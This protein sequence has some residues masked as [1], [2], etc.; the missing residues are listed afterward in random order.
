MR[1]L[2]SP[3]SGRARLAAHG[4]ESAAVCTKTSAN[5]KSAADSR[6]SRR[7]RRRRPTRA[8]ATEASG[9]GQTRPKQADAGRCNRR[10]KAQ[11]TQAGAAEMGKHH[12]YASKHNRCVL[13]SRLNRSRCKTHQP[14]THPHVSQPK[15]IC[16][17]LP[18]L[19]AF[20]SKKRPK[21]FF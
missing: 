4:R 19:D 9:R 8:G 13:C 18:F 17:N 1:H 2:R 11:P 7:Q 20:R 12:P 3:A 16:R 21:K 10:K 15:T 6:P 14:P 5:A